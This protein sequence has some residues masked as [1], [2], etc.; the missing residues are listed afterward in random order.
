MKLKNVISIIVS[1]LTIMLGG[2]VLFN[3][4]FILLALLVNGFEV[5]ADS[6]G[7]VSREMLQLASY[8][9]IA[10]AIAVAAKFLLT[11]EQLKH[12]LLA[13]MFALLI[14]VV[15]VMIGIALYKQSDII[16]LLAGGVVII[17]ILILLFMKKANWTYIFATVYASSLGILVMLFNIEI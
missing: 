15:L 13:S 17:P 11:K 5:F 7:E 9:A 14:M 10:I 3:L 1:L 4:A 2:F 16:I 12:T 8:V 6:A